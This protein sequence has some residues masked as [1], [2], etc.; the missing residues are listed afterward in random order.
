M[1]NDGDVRFVL[2]GAG[3]IGG[4]VGGRLS[5]H[6]YEVAFVARGAHGAEIERNGLR[7]H[8]PA[9]TTTVNAQVA[10]S[11]GRIELAEPGRGC[12]LRGA[13]SQGVHS[14][15]RGVR[16]RGHESFELAYRRTI[17]VPRDAVDQTGVL[18]AIQIA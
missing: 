5:E 9:G 16:D 10:G 17:F 7:V 6:G 18:E 15:D 12:Q 4:V 3:A 2:I 11:P 8:S 14:C 13:Y 1:W